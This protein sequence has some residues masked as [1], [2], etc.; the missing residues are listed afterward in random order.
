MNGILDRIADLKGARVLVVEDDSDY[1]EWIAL[2]LL[3]LGVSDI[4]K[5]A[6]GESALEL[7]RTEPEFDLIICDWLMPK[8]DGLDFL[9]RF[10]EKV[11]S[12][13]F[14][15]LTAKS[16]LEDAFEAT[17]AGATNYLV[18]PLSVGELQQQVAS[19]LS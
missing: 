7:T 17:Q 9:K 6:D 19:M 10:R 12:S 15:V 13:M 18:K 4:V 1:A 14:L 8:M 2:A 11:T 16:D 5:A 3:D